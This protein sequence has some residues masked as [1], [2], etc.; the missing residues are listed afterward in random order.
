[1][2]QIAW[3]VPEDAGD[4][5]PE[6]RAAPESLTGT[7]DASAELG[8]S[9]LRTPE[10]DEL[11]RSAEAHGMAG[12]GVGK[13]DAARLRSMVARRLFGT[14]ADP[15]RIGRF[16]VLRRLGAGGMGVVY[17]GFDEQLDR[18][19]AI[20]LLLTS[21]GGS[22]PKELEEQRARLMREAQAMAKLSHPN[23]ITV[24]DVG[25][26]RGQVFV[27]M[28]FIDGTTLDG[29]RKAEDRTWREVLDVFLAAGSGLAAAHH[30]GLVH[31]DFKPDNVLVGD[32]GRVRVADFG[33]ARTPGATLVD[34]V[35]EG[36]GQLDAREPTLT[37]T[38]VLAGTPGYMSPE[39]F[40]G[41]RVDA[42]A[43]QFAFCVAL[44]EA[45]WGVRPFEG[46][47]L[48][49]LAAA[50]VAGRA[51]T[52][53]TEAR[54]EFDP[55]LVSAIGSVVERGLATAPEDRFASMS[56][57]IEQLRE[58]TAKPTDGALAV[59]SSALE[60]ASNRGWKP[61]A[62]AASL[63]STGF[64][65]FGL[66]GE[67]GPVEPPAVATAKAEGSAAAAGVEAAG[68]KESFERRR[69]ASRR[70]TVRSS[71]AF[72]PSVVECANGV[73]TIPRSE[74][75]MGG[76]GPV[77]IDLQAR[78]VPALEDGVSIGVKMYGVREG[79]ILD[80]LGIEV[81]DTVTRLN[82]LDLGGQ[83]VEKVLGAAGDLKTIDEVVVAFRR[84]GQPRTLTVRL[85]D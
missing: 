44:H 29:W 33:M 7:I 45:V 59:S 73:C 26:F 58:A 10:R 23:V 34:E 50:V 41:G 38:G 16:A 52:F 13:V 81:G 36:D 1:M 70:Q 32:D 80:A 20:K 12:P 30:G 17:S 82:H 63:A 62:V 35:D 21:L 83:G 40:E 22:L 67:P 24:H 5:G 69:T 11:S 85:L 19:V 49:E 75:V 3:V 66:R 53:E 77:A 68:A 27:A 48:G 2:G 39:Q 25:E 46:E 8:A 57:L 18:K 14:A 72:D 54:A 61:G 79:S 76:D 51:S 37:R 74:F 6:G 71:S 78:F 31:R 84:D 65:L 42:R 28:E 9:G 56:E 64:L 15:V 47:T 43:D 55:H 4:D 60:P